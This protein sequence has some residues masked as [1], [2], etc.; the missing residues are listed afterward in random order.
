MASSFKSEVVLR[1]KKDGRVDGSSER[2]D[3]S[4]PPAAGVLNEGDRVVPTNR[5]SAVSS[6]AT[7]DLRRR[8]PRITRRI[9][10]FM[11]SRE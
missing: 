4:L 3:S 7:L 11:V 6:E 2:I 5:L 10:F 8:P 9:R 1:E